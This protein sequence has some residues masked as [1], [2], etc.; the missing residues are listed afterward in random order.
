MA[1]QDEDRFPPSNG[2]TVGWFGI[3]LAVV[4]A[5]LVVANG[6]Q[7]QDL[8]ALPLLALFAYIVWAAVLQTHAAIRDG[9]L[10]LHN[11]FHTTRVPL[12]SVTG[13]EVRMA[14]LIR[15][16]GGDRLTF[17]AISRSRR[18]IA[19]N[20]PSDPLTNYPDLVEE[21]VRHRAD[22]AREL[23]QETGPVVRE[24]SVVRIGI[25][26]AL[27]ALSAAALLLV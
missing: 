16:D 6:F 9:Q 26:V 13:A 19:R 8:A 14:L 25:G 24:L 2:R 21:R 15:L 1:L 11:T 4:G 12:A 18:E 7:R 23:G 5:V 20:A 10:E 3:V 17:A 27:L 22:E